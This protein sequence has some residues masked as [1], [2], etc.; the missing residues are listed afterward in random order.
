MW[1]LVT[2]LLLTMIMGRVQSVK[3]VLDSDHGDNNVTQVLTCQSSS[4][5]FFCVWESAGGE[6]LCSVQ[7]RDGVVSGS[8]T[9]G[10][11]DGRLSLGGNNTLCSLTIDNVGL[12]DNGDWTCV[13]TDH[14]MDTVKHH[15][16]LVVEQEGVLSVSSN[17]VSV[18]PG[19]NVELTCALEGVWPVAELSW[20]FSVDGV[21]VDTDQVTRGET[22]VSS[23]CEQCPVTVTQTASIIV[24]PQHNGL[25][26]TCS[27][28]DTHDV[29]T[30]E[31]L[32]LEAADSSQLIDFSKKIGVLPGVVISVLLV[33]L[34][35][36]ILI[37]FC[38]RGSRK[39]KHSL[40]TSNSEDPEL[41]KTM[42]DATNNQSN[43]IKNT[44][45]KLQDV[46]DVVY[47]EED[48][49]LTDNSLDS[50]DTSDTNKD[51]SSSTSSDDTCNNEKSS[52]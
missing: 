8:D 16:E 12:A 42:I 35:I 41:G 50:S 4:P 33:L 36:A 14:N 38:V 13:L 46:I 6:R 17:S 48:N 40:V 29:T 20:S 19:D 9:C 21:E 11:G 52:S 2:P 28:H 23:E 15:T 25:L 5:W 10:H 30:I 47:D 1:R 22:V 37:S 45:S 3:V 26:V 49:S 43:I 31:V 18:Y 7:D 51:N 27:S 34:S 24:T 32:A 44:E 39:R